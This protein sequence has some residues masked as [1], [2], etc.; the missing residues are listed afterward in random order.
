M[1]SCQSEPACIDPRSVGLCS[2]VAG[3]LFILLTESLLL[4]LR[5]L[6]GVLVR[7][8]CAALGAV[9]LE[10]FS[11]AGWL[12]LVGWSVYIRSWLQVV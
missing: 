10:H 11:L 5:S 8:V 9:L 6:T 7:F 4:G 12:C 2:A 1:C 3:H